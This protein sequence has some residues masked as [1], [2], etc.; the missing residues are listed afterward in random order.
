MA[1]SEFE[2]LEEREPDR[3]VHWRVQELRRA[4]YAQLEAAELAMHSDIDI[5]LAADLLIQG[6]CIKTALRI[7]L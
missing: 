2:V 1:T 3:V 5:H 6:C 4:G 7:L